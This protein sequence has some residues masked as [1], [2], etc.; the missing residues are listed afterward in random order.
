MPENAYNPLEIEPKWQKRWEEAGVFKASDFPGQKK[1]Y[2]LDMF[3]YPSGDGLHVGHVK[4]YIATDVYAR[5]KRMQGFEV[6]HPMGWD[7]FGLPAE[8]YAIANKVH[9]RE[10]V[11]KNIARFK[12]QLGK[13]GFTYDW[14]REINTT[15][16][17]YYRWTQWIFLQLFTKGLAYES[18]EVINWCPRDKTG[19]ANED[20]E[21]GRCER[22]GTLV[23][24][25]KMRQW[26]LKI[27]DYADRLLKDLD[28]LNW[29]E[30][31]TESQ[32]N[33]IGRSE[34][35]EIEFSITR[36]SNEPTPGPEKLKFNVRVY[37]TRADTL[38][39][40]TYL[41]LAPEHPFVAELLTG[42][43]ELSI[44]NKAEVAEYI[45]AAEH[46]TDLDRQ[47]DEKEKT[48]VQLKGIVA[49]NPAN[50]EEITVWAAD[51][52]LM[53]YGTGA[54]MAVPAHDERDFA[55]AK[56]FGLAVREVIIPHPHSSAHMKSEEG[57][58]ADLPYIGE[59]VLVHSGEFDG[60]EREQAKAAVIKKVGGE[61]KIM[62]KLRNWVFS[63]QRYWGEPI[64]LIFCLE[65]KRRI[66]TNNVQSAQST[67]KTNITHYAPQSESGY[68]AGEL[69]NPGWVAVPQEQLPVRLPE[70]ASYQPSGT[71]ESP[72]AA[73]EDWVNVR[74]PRCGGPARRETNTMP[75]W[76]GSCWYYLRYLDPKNDAELV[77]PAK[78]KAW[79]PVDLYVGGAEHATRHLIYAR[80]WHKFLF[81]IG[82]VST[83]EPFRK[84]KNVGLILGADGRKMSKRWG[85]VLNPDAVTARHGAD[86]LRVYEMFMGP[87][88]NAMP[89]S[90][91]SLIGAARFLRRVNACFMRPEYS[92]KKKELRWDDDNRRLVMHR[93]IKRV[94]DAIENFRFNTGV[95]AL[96]E[97]LNE[98]EKTDGGGDEARRVFIR[99]LAP[100]APHAAE[101]LWENIGGEGF[102]STAPW[103]TYD[104]ALLARAEVTVPVQVNGK[105]RGQ[106]TLAADADHAAAEAAARALI[107]V[108][109]HLA[110]TEVQQIVYVPGRMINFVK[111]TV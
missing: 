24:K 20:I 22:C 35:S 55:F 69:M 90:E 46:K 106:V 108:Q 68:S 86:A 28:E 73:I 4:G 107:N 71:G 39:G 60:M 25:K 88:E 15:D 85:N 51:Y 110:N 19:L 29:P 40:V 17:E 32:R 57:G 81:D 13:I 6:L 42:N 74:C 97:W 66:E 45:R 78:E 12:E 44:Q 34:G 47:A 8:N 83:S 84:L 93:T 52:V 41:V 27:T 94:T 16:P 76:A 91:E 18:D 5:F 54:I 64:P 23:E 63:R 10:A 103:P 77:D 9:P 79:M 80:F 87:F 59:G 7:A 43:L 101:D 99:L 14:D 56:K 33:W 96:M 3:P 109:R 82:A 104:D 100:Y 65:C 53:S 1:Q 38:F 26:V 49:I 48:G 102:V 21:D 105:V 37:T 11:E 89:W 70:V 92:T 67:H 72:L 95:A 75:Q 58:A 30:S 111:R 2:V 36:P 50:G 62:Y 61:T 98:L 31:I